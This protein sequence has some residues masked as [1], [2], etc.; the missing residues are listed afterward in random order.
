MLQSIFLGIDYFLQ[1]IR[2]VVLLYLV[3][4]W[5]VRP[6]NRLMKILNR[7]VD[8]MLRPVRNVLFRF[9]PSMMIDPSPIL[10]FLLMDIVRRF[11]WQLYYWIS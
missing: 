1:I 9:L 11:M 3:L 7:I 8:P 4:S 6:Y 2:Y 5:F 10:L